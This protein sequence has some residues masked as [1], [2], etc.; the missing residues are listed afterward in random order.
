MSGGKNGGAASAGLIVQ[1]REALAKEALA[2]LAHLGSR[3]VESLGDGFVLESLCGQQ[4]QSGS[5]DVAI[6]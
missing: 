6:G 3:Q 1:T 4:D 2:P 5:Y